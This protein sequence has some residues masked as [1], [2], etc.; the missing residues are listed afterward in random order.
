MCDCSI[1]QQSLTNTLPTRDIILLL[2]NVQMNQNVHI[3]LARTRSN[4]RAGSSAHSE[5]KDAC[6]KYVSI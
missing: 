1:S 5:Q 6:L 2:V 4:E 3:I